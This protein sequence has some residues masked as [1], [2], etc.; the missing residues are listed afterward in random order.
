MFDDLDSLFNDFFGS[1]EEIRKE[2]ERLKGIVDNL[3][4]FENLN[5]EM[6]FEEEELGEPD[7]TITY[8]ENGYT[9]EKSIWNLEH[10]SIVKVQMISS[11]LDTGFTL[12]DFKD[13]YNP[14]G[15]TLEQKLKFAIED[16]RYEVL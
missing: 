11:P 2:F 7:E 9:F 10:G 6:S 5:G 13:K 4:Y 1:D 14:K 3:N 12:K 8:T 16:E 15:L